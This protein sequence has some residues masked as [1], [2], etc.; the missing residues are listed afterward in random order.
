MHGD[1]KER[2]EWNEL[3]RQRLEHRMDQA[4]Q[5]AAAERHT[6][7]YKVAKFLWSLKRLI[8]FKR[9]L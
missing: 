6:L 5:Q 1:T 9:S 3:D 8:S 4:F 2:R 7:K